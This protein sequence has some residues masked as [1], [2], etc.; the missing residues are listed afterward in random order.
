M[1]ADELLETS[2]GSGDQSPAAAQR[3][4]DARS[5]LLLFPDVQGD[6]RGK[7]LVPSQLAS[8]RVWSEGLPTTDLLLAVDPV[9]EPITT[10]TNTGL[11]GGA[12]DLL[13]RPDPTTIRPLPW[14]PDCRV[15]LGDL[16][17]RD[18]SPSPV[19]PRQVLQKAL[20]GL[21]SRG[22]RLQAA[23]EYEFRLFAA[24][25]WEPAS[26]GPSYSPAVL[27]QVAGFVE[28]FRSFADDLRLGL[29][30]LHSEGAPGLV[31]VN[32]DPQWGVAAA[33]TAALLKLAALE[34]ARRHGLR[35]V[36]MA[37]PVSGE[38][39][40]SAHVH[41]SMWDAA[42]AN[43]L[44][45]SAAEAEHELYR[46]AAWGLLKHL[47]A[48]SLIY[49][50]TVNSYK[51][52]VPGFFAPVSAACGPEDRSFAVRALLHGSTA[53][54]FELRRP[55]ADCNPYLTLAA[56]AASISVGLGDEVVPSRAEIDRHEGTLPSTLESAIAE[57][58]RRDRR[59]DEQLGAEF[60]AH[61]LITREWELASWQNAVTDWERQRY[62]SAK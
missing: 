55:G 60:A 39:G 36:F 16:H 30:V 31:E 48:L 6:L 20:A 8:D 34:A 10:F 54:R 15:V 57:F 9:D 5:A 47:P 12:R 18:G 35:A 21:E 53:S 11:N 28:T 41:F 13:L 49:N 51:R 42:G 59:I 32:V 7:M 38:E 50:P 1:H 37:K 43:V 26:T 45:G 3:L 40:S 52:L 44:A 33:D 25:G 19:S 4:V 14:F 29:S 17:L 24:G 27:S 23:F 22:L 61:F 46:R 58:K 62:S 2:F 56:I